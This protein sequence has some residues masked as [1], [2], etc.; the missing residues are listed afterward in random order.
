MTRRL[1]L[2]RHA[3][4]DHPVGVDDERRPLAERGR[5]DSARMGRHIARKG[6]LPDLALV[7]TARRADETWQAASSA[8]GRRVPVRNE[9]R[10]YNASP[11]GLLELSKETEPEVGSLLLVGHNPGLHE[12][13]LAL[14][15]SGDAEDRARLRK[16]LPTA[17]L[18]IIDFEVGDWSALARGLGILKGFE[19]PDA[20]D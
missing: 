17:G 8:F 13:A 10:L 1:M 11:R 2:F 20:L 15:G 16:G 18:V 4:S 19:T 6:L 12:F 5:R 9:A 14:V 7:S 3:K